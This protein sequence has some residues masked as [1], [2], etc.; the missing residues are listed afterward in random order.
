MNR[1][2][3]PRET[4]KKRSLFD[5]SLFED[6]FILDLANNHQGDIEHATKIIR[7]TG[8]VV[9]SEGV[10]SALKFQFRDLDTFVHK[11]HQVGSKNKHIPRFLSTR[12]SWADFEMLAKEVKMAGMF[13]MATPFDETSVLKII[14]MDLDLIKIASCSAGDRPLLESVARARKPVIVS[15]GGLTVSQIDHVVH[16]FQDTGVAFGLMHCVAIYPTPPENLNLNQID[17]LKNRYPEVPVG[18]STHEDPNLTWPVQI[19]QAKGAQ[20]FERH[21]GMESEKYSLN[22]YSSTPAQLMNWFK[23]WK[24]AETAGGGTERSPAPPDEMESL[25]SLRRGVYARHAIEKGHVFTNADVYFAMPLEMGKLS[26][27]EWRQGLHADQAYNADEPLSME[28][29]NK[30]S[31]QEECIAQILLQVRGMLNNA[32]ICIGKKSAIE[33]SHH[34]GIDRFREYGCV[35]ITCVNRAYSKKIVVQLPRQKHPYHYHPQKEETFQLLGGD[36]EVEIEGHRYRLGLGDMILVEPGKWHK[37]HT[38]DGAI[39]EEI[40]TTHLPNDSI[41]E[42]EFIN[43]LP[44]G[45]R[46]TELSNWESIILV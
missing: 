31:T 5:P 33:I 27:N 32:R 30:K 44:K 28:V 8:E 36:L 41:Y 17:F 34:Y 25:R 24:M 35:L 38:L 39:F 6:L 15:T 4:R 9:R 42:D 3:L 29:A 40:S 18:F 26:S 7:Q 20:M 13:T 11:T 16:L 37:F 22:A 45:K 19:A 21:V 43:Q 46:K 2:N 10:R 12:L 14:E 23:S 1:F